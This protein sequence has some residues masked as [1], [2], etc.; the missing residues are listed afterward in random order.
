MV[1]SPFTVARRGGRMPAL[2]P[3]STSQTRGEVSD[4]LNDEIESALEQSRGAQAEKCENGAPCLAIKKEGHWQ[5]L[6]GC[7]NDWTCARCGHMRAREEYG[8]IVHGARELHAEGHP[9]YF[10]TLTCKGKE[11]S[12]REAE[13]GYM[14]WTNRFLTAIRTEAARRGVYWSYVQVTERQKRQHPHSHLITTYT[15]PD[16]KAYR[17]GQF[18]PGRRHAPHDMLYSKY[19]WERAEEA[20]LGKETDMS[21]ILNPIAVAVYVSKYLFK[22]AMNTVFPANWRRVRYARSFPKLPIQEIE[23]FPLVNHSDW[24]KLRR[25]GEPMITFDP[26]VRDTAYAHLV[27]DVL[28]K[29]RGS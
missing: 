22:S 5:V 15:P 29:Q 14:E 11:M 10:L 3:F 16:G 20:G 24:I 1:N 9:L 19:V 2:D 12:V 26:V 18:I 27:T 6:Q 8:R 17:K 4:R 28:Y 7:C 23:G 21:V 25:M 13:A